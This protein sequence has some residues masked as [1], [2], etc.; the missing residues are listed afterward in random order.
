MTAEEYL[1]EHGIS[2][3]SVQK[4]GLKSVG[5]ELIIPIKDEAGK[6][7]Y[8]KYRNLDFDKDNPLSK[9]FRFD[10]GNRAT[11]FNIQALINYEKFNFIFLCEGEPDAIRLDQEGLL[12]I[13][14]T[15]GVATFKDEWAEKLRGKNVFIL[16][17]NDEEGIKGVE[18][19]AQQL[20][21]T[22]A[23]PRIVNLPESVKDVCEFFAKG[24][25]KA[26]LL[27]LL[28]S[29]KVIERKEDEAHKFSGANKISWPSPLSE[30]AFYGLAGEIIKAIEPHSEAD[31]A[32]LLMNFLTAYGSVIGDKPHFRV[33]ADKHPM[34]LFTVLVGET[35]KAR[36]GTSWGYIRNIFVEI[37]EVWGRNLQTGLSSGEG[38]IW[39]VRDKGIKKQPIKQNGRTVD[40]E[41]VIIDEGITD[42]R[43][44]IIES[45]FA[46]TLRVL[47]RDGNTLSPIIRSAWDSGNLQS[48]TKN[49]PAKATGAHV[50]IIGHITRQELLRYLTETETGNGFGNRFLLCC[51]RRSKALAF[52]GELY[53]IDLTSLK[54]KLIESIAFAN[55]VEEITW[56]EET[57]PLWSSVYPRLSEGKPGLIGSMTARAEAYV[58]RLAGIYALL[59]LS[60]T[61]HPQHLNAALGIWNYVEES[62]KYIFQDRTGDSVADAILDYL[63]QHPEGATRTEISNIFDRHRSSE[64]ISDSL[65]TLQ[66]LGWVRKE[67]IAGE[68]RSIE[69]WFVE[70]KSE[71]S[72]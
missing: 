60:K 32:A 35:S 13:C 14:G 51:V 25:A 38:L 37:D 19:V 31:S 1:N 11:L 64:Q 42:K 54:I 21:S 36:K 7:L 28:K 27:K 23:N 68:G 29:S 62:V 12:A 40:Y 4:F 34:R 53:K 30:R 16:F 46:A 56:A 72:E 2:E 39:A 18:K 47:G 20:L 15:A 24:Q 41:E 58:I 55:Q 10:F 57:K 22:K 5:T 3:A 48:L 6:F 49:S 59:D 8:N 44:L 61:I 63:L 66:F 43:L 65:S 17:D 69:T 33:E 26:D 67:T 52:G 50:S 70:R 45:E 9:K 71:K